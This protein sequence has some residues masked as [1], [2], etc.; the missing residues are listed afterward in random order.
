MLKYEKMFTA[1]KY[2]ILLKINIV[3]SNNK[4]VD[5]IYINRLLEKYCEI[6]IFN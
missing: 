6:N 1:R 2:L 3:H 5:K 4:D